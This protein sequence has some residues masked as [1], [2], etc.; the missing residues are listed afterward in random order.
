MSTS[1]SWI[2]RA[3]LNLGLAAAAVAVALGLGEGAL[4]ALGFSYTNFWQPDPVMGTVLR[5]GIQGWEV[6]EGHAFVRINSRGLR[7]REHALAKP[8]GTYRI[9]I[10]GDS[11]A[12]AKQVAR[13]RTFWWILTERLASCGFAPGKTIET[14]NFGV[15][16]YG[17]AHELLMLQNRVWQYQPDMVLLAFFPGNDVRNNSQAL[18]G[19]KRP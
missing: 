4:R 12:E 18:E 14:V 8:A 11:Y 13:E 1:S 2:K 7:D 10:L 3:L 16:G 19:E 15:S 17:T 6:D 5:P 9:A